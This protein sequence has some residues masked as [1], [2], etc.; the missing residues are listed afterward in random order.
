MENITSDKLKELLKEGKPV[1]VDYW[2]SWCGPCRQLIPRLEELET[3]FPNV[4]FVKVDV[5]ENQDYA[6]EMGIRGVP[7]VMI[8]NNNELIDRTSG[9]HPDG[10]YK[11][12]LSEL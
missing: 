9:V 3:K 10:H 5:D 7:T 8:Y 12:F 4:K 11:K 6:V 1:L 2:A